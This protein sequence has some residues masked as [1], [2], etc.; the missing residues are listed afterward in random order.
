MT[1]AIATP[2]TPSLNTITSIR[3]STVFTIPATIRLYSGLLL[4]PVLLRIDEPKSYNIINGIPRRYI[5][6]YRTARSITSSGVPIRRSTG[7]AI[8]CP[9]IIT[10]T[11]LITA[12]TIAVCTAAFI[13]FS[14]L[15][16]I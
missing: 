16:P 9:A 12:T 11:P 15:C 1:V 5:L 4:S 3:L 8:N 7:F 10:N 6:R 2:D 14:A 13:F